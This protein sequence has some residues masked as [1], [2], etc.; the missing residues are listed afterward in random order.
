MWN[1]TPRV[2][3]ACGWGQYKVMPL[4]TLSSLSGGG[5]KLEYR[6]PRCIV[7][8][9]C[10]WGE[11]EFRFLRGSI[12]SWRGGSSTVV[13]EALLRHRARATRRVWSYR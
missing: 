2:S 13:V 7:V 1:R 10:V 11:W 9:V 5:G 12:F 8:V 3:I 6:F 4:G